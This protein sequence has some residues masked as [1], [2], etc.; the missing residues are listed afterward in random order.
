MGAFFFSSSHVSSTILTDFQQSADKMGVGGDLRKITG[1][2]QIEHRRDDAA[3][4]PGEEEEE[5]HQG[6]G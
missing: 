3:E 2:A 6:R 5:E 1:I 4:G